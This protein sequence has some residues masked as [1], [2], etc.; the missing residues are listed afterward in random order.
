MAKNYYDLIHKYKPHYSF[1]TPSHARELIKRPTDMSNSI[2]IGFGGDGFDDV[3]QAMNNYMK[4]NNSNSYAYQ[5]YGSTEMSAVAIVN[6][7]KVHKIG[8]L[9]KPSGETKAI[10]IEPDTFN[11]ITEPNKIGE[12]CLTGPGLTLGYAGNSK[13]E[14]DNVFVKHP[15]GKT[16]VHMGDYISFDE[17]G[18]YFYHGR[19]KNVI[20]RKSFKFSP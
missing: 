20:A 5:G 2:I 4:N 17:E 10:I 15:D 14:T 6:T 3:E 13:A 12:L 8:A 9:G 1:A 18:F 19:I 7:P 16:Y 11:V